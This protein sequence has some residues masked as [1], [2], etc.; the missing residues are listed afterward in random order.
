MGCPKAA[1]VKRAYALE[2][3]KPVENYLD[4]PF[5]DF[6]RCVKDTPTIRNRVIRMF[7]Q[8]Y[9]WEILLANIA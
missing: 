9:S 6:E 7:L 8:S 1:F 4:S 3:W 5:H 2:L